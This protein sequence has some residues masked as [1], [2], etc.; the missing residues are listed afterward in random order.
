M[1]TL[2]LSSF[3]TWQGLF[4]GVE[5]TT[6]WNRLFEP[7]ISASAT[8]V[9][10]VRHFSLRAVYIQPLQHGHKPMFQVGASWKVF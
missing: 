8:A 4:V 3:L 2:L 9:V 7:G 5:Q 1:N 6:P 10:S